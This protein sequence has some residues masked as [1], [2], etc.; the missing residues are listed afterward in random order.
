MTEKS[1]ILRANDVSLTYSAESTAGSGPGTAKENGIVYGVDLTVRKGEWVALVGENGSG[2]S[3]LAKALAGVH[4]VSGGNIERAGGKNTDVRIV[5]QNPE[6]QTVGD[7]VYEDVVFGLENRGFSPEEAAR[8]ARVALELVGLGDSAELPVERLSG[9][10]KQLLA[11]AGALAVDAPVI[12]FDEATSM[13]DPAARELVLNVVLELH[14]REKTI[15]WITQLMDELAWAERVIVMKG[16]TVVFE[17]SPERFFY[18]EGKGE[19]VSPCERFGFVPPY[20]VQV[21][22]ELMSRGCALPTLPLTPEQLGEAVTA[23]CR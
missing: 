13:L 12:V 17:G 4:P 2:K 23:L 20:A 1:W 21:A 14:R 8:R 15:I 16:G 5:L 9:G 6:A 18:G 3:T 7:T 10:R 11:I 22:A 19:S